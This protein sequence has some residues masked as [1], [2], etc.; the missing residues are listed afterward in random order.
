MFFL[1]FSLYVD[2]VIKLHP[3]YPPNSLILPSFFSSYFFLSILRNV[4]SPQD[5]A[6]I[7]LLISITPQLDYLIYFQ[8]LNFTCTLMNLKFISPY[9]Y[10]NIDFNYLLALLPFGYLTDI[11]NSTY[12]PPNTPAPVLTILVNGTVTH[13]LVQDRNMVNILGS[14]LF[15]VTYIQIKD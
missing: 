6:H 14:F 12:V 3:D 13:S 7:V 9:Q 8:C 10:T 2:C 5:L 15:P 11:S 4:Y 1:K